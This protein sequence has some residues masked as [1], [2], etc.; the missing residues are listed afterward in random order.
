MNGLV[1]HIF[2][3]DRGKHTKSPSRPELPSTY[4]V[5]WALHSGGFQRYESAGLITEGEAEGLSEALWIRDRCYER[6]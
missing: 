6:R 1:S 3:R 4:L 2:F 5:I